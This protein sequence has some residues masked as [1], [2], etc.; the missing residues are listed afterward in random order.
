MIQSD[1]ETNLEKLPEQVSNALLEWRVAT[2]DREKLEAILRLQYSVE[3][4][5]ATEVTALVHSNQERYDVVLNEAKAESHYT[6]LY[7]KLMA[8]KKEAT[9]R[10]AF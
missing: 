6:F 1:L 4:R 9:M 10:G 5:K 3:D 2:L 8:A 7:E